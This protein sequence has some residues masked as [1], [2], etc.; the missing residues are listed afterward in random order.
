MTAVAIANERAEKA[1]LAKVPDLVQSLVDLLGGKPVAALAGVKQTRAVGTWIRA[2]A[3]PHLEAEQRLRLAAK[4]AA[5]LSE[6]FEPSVVRAWF[7]GANHRLDDEMPLAMIATQPTA[8]VA[9]QILGAA[10]ELLA[11]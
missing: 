3:V 6:R 10:R 4:A 5:I 8:D 2:E 9:K 7:F 1:G 11:L